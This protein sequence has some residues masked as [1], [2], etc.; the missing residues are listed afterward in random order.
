MIKQVAEQVASAGAQWLRG[1]AYKPRTSP[2]AF[3]GKG[4]E[5]LKWL[6]EAADEHGLKVVTE[7]LSEQS[8]EQVAAWSDVVQIGTRNMQNFAL[9]KAVGATRRPVLLKRGL[10]A[11]IEEWLLAGE[12]LLAHGAEAVVFCE[13]GLRSFD[14]QT[15]NLLDLGAV[16]LLKHSYGQPVVVDPSH[17]AGRRDLIAP[18]TRASLAVGADGVMVESHPDAGCAMSDGPQALNTE[19][20]QRLGR[21]L[22]SFS[23]PQI[24]AERAPVSATTTTQRA[25][26][27]EPLSDPINTDPI[28]TDPIKTAPMKI[29]E[30]SER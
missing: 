12:Y 22:R 15:R 27:S 28:N 3:Q 5:G 13:R 29:S 24:L 21:E 18:L 7:A 19:E 25:S 30:W 1:G 9:L 4:E 8:A 11:T 14:P 20:L 17:A 10:C 16:A 6:R 26:L 23:A 2:Y